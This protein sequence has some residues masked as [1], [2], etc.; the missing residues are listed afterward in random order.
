MMTTDPHTLLAPYALDALDDDERR[1]FEE[2][3]G[4]CAECA[5]ELAGFV[6]T[7]ARLGGAA[8]APAPAGLRDAVLAAASRTPQVRPLSAPVHRRA[9]W[10]RYVQRGLLAAA[11][12]VLVASV[13]GFWLEHERAGDIQAEAVSVSQ[14]LAA[15]DVRAASH[16]LPDGGTMTVASSSSLDRAVVAVNGLPVTDEGTVYQLWMLQGDVPVPNETFVGG[17]GSSSHLFTDF[18]AA[19]AVAIT[20]EPQGGSTTPTTTPIA[21]V[22]A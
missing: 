15:P 5:E 20:V 14:V 3:V 17:E 19:D 22:N 9:A 2:H 12:A 11:A 4:T 13:G 16:E 18:D 6:E 7:A 1:A 10:P 21:V 8:S